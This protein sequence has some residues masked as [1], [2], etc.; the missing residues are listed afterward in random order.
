[1]FIAEVFESCEI[2][3]EEGVSAG[4]RR[5]TALTGAKAAEHVKR[6][7]LVIVWL[8]ACDSSRKSW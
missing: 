3:S 5:I 4:T 2:L 6:L 8:M 7:D 1:M